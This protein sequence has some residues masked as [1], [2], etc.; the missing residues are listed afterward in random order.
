MTAF[1]PRFRE[2]AGPGLFALAVALCAS[3]LCPIAAAQEPGR[4]FRAS[5]ALDVDSQLARKLG[6]V[7]DYIRERQWEQAIDALQEAITANAAALIP[8]EP[9]RYVNAADHARRMLAAFPAEGRA[10]YRHRFDA[11]ARLWFEAGRR[12]RSIEPLEQVVR[13][14]YLS[15]YG[16]DALWL[17]GELAWERGDITAARSHWGQL[18]PLARPVPTGEAAPVLCYPDSDLDPALVLARL[19]LCSVMEGDFDRAQREQAEFIQAHPQAAGTLAGQSGNLSEILARVAADARGWSFPIGDAAATFG[20]DMRR[21]GRVRDAVEVGAVAWTQPL[22]PGTL[23]SPARKRALPDNPVVHYPVVW[24]DIVL[25]PEENRI[26][27]WSIATG[28]P[29]PDPD[30]EDAILYPPAPEPALAPEGPLV[31]MPAYTATIHEGRLYARLGT[32]IIAEARN[33]FRPLSRALVCLDLERGEGKPVWTTTASEAAGGESGWTFEG[34]PVVAGGRCFVTLRRS[35]PETQVHA[36]CIDAE[37]GRPLWNR[38]IAAA[39]SPVGEGQNLAGHL[40]LAFDGRTLYH[41]TE[42]GAIAALDADDGTL[43][44]VVTYESQRPAQPGGTFRR[45]VVPCVVDG[46]FVFAAPADSRSI[47]AIHA[48]TGIVLWENELNENVRHLLGTGGG[49]LIVSGRSLWG[50]DIR[51]G[52]I[53][54]GRPEPEPAETGYGRG[55]LV[56]DTVWWPTRES[57]EIVSQKTGQRIRAP[58]DL[59]AKGAGG[60]HLIIAAGR[61]LV[62]QSGGLIAFANEAGSGAAEPIPGTAA[63]P[64]H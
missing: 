62:V 46:E 15:S 32:P 30:R 36:V 42:L 58:I 63:R 19:I 6:T 51:S 10:V 48:P 45:G 12:T 55:L 2:T 9:G 26:R 13:Q 8:A 43:R 25:V 54:W 4:R 16:D 3:W 14:A 64:R 39:V 35:R 47:F 59:Q 17:L 1:G 41:T 38:R 18:V 40:L 21:N 28:R 52:A 56:G 53:A 20:G 31:G 44:W 27:A 24:R 22:S 11:Q 37:T 49:N 61:L 5:V 33:E 7:R 57:I 60:G 34:S 23:P 50:L 29:W